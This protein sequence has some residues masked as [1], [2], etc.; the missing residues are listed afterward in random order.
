MVKIIKNFLK[1]IQLCLNLTLHNSSQPTFQRRQCLKILDYVF[2]SLHLI[3]H[4]SNFHVLPPDDSLLNHF[5]ISF[6]L[7]VHIA[8]SNLPIWCFISYYKHTS[9][10][11]HSHQQCAVPSA[12]NFVKTFGIHQYV[13]FLFLLLLPLWGAG[14]FINYLLREITSF[15]IFSD[16]IFFLIKKI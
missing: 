16:S 3:L 2:S 5:F 11:F 9:L 6:E 15:L 13:L 4:I 8:F 12:N 10:H 14:K 1:L 7:S